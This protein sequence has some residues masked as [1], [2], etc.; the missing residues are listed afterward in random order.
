MLPDRVSNP[1]PLTYESG[2]LLIALCSPAS[3]ELY[4]KQ[5]GGSFQHKH[6]KTSFLTLLHSERPKL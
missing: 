3:F 6:F 1:G 5:K 4:F 2:A